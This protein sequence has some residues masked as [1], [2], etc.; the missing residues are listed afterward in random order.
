[1]PFQSFLPFPDGTLPTITPLWPGRFI[2]LYFLPPVY[3]ITFLVPS[4]HPPI[5][6]R[7]PRCCFVLLLASFFYPRV[8]S[9]D[10]CFRVLWIITPNLS[11]GL[12][13]SSTSPPP[14]RISDQHSFV[15]TLSR[16]I[17]VRM[18]VCIL[19]CDTSLFPAG[20]GCFSGPIF[21]FAC[22]EPLPAAPPGVVRA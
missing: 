12:K 1:M 22:R 2:V 3:S 9:C 14:D 20:L 8:L 15:K 21:W 10:D 19:V 5:C 11:F 6:P 18:I 4:L 17:L 13:A 16:H 7:P